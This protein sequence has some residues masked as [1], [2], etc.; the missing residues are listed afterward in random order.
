MY[1]STADNIGSLLSGY[2]EGKE[3]MGLYIF[4]TKRAASG[5]GSQWLEVEEGMAVEEGVGMEG[6]SNM[7]MFGPFPL[8][9]PFR[10]TLVRGLRKYTPFN[11]DVVQCQAH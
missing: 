11:T 2:G 10:D 1:S 7:V 8:I 5:W 3:N 9:V 6:D 4:N